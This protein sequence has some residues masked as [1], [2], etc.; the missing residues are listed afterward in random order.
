MIRDCKDTVLQDFSDSLGKKAYCTDDIKS[1][2]TLLP[3]SYA[4]KKKYV[5]LNQKLAFYVW[6]DIDNLKSTMMVPDANVLVQRESCIG[7]A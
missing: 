1:G 6:L 7:S 3:K 2:V 4:I 5:G